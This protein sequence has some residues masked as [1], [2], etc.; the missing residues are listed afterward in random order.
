MKGNG[1]LVLALLIAVLLSSCAY[2]QVA[3]PLPP[4]AQ[5]APD[6]QVIVMGGLAG[7]D[8]VNVT[9]PDVAQPAALSAD[10][11][12]LAGQLGVSPDQATV[13]N[14]ALP[15]TEAW[16]TKYRVPVMTSVTFVAQNAA[17]VDNGYLPVEKL[18]VGLRNYRRL[19][20]T[21]IMPPNFQYRGFDRY[22]DR[23]VS[24]LESRSGSTYTFSVEINNPNFNSLTLPTVQVPPAQ[25]AAPV[26]SSG[27]WI[28]YLLRGLGVVL[29]CCFAA[30]VGWGV[31]NVLLKLR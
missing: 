16:N 29:I 28:V 14:S 18:I 19:A 20:I 21:Y 26:R 31:Y 1:C 5:S 8:Q 25:L 17:P 9:Y 24:I 6:L 27:N 2:G 4:I 15:L 10:I 3:I 7:G 11:K 13:T 22:S 30:M 12:A 23:N